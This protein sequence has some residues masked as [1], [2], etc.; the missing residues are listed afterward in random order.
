MDHVTS[1]PAG[2]ERRPPD[3]SSSLRRECSHLAEGFAGVDLRVG[4]VFLGLMAVV[5]GDTS[6]ATARAGL[7]G[8]W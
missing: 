7:G 3:Q 5:A 1:W 8:T 6:G 2:W 4:Y